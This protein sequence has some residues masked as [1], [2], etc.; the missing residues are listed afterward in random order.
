MTR[1]HLNNTKVAV[2]AGTFDPVTNGHVDIITRAACLYEKV[3]VAVSDHGRK[4]TIFDLNQRLEAMRLAT[5]HLSNVEVVG[6]SNLLYQL[7]EEVGAGVVIRGLRMTSDFD[8]EFQMAEMNQNLSASF[9]TVVLMA[10]S[11]HSTISS[12]TVKEVAALGGDISRF[13]PPH[14]L[15][16]LEKIYDHKNG[17]HATRFAA[18]E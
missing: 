5:A 2:Y 7:V 12:T 8:Y 14:V 6:F 1:Q 11:E 15:E 18:T 13:V 10:R 3:H 17:A 4:N 9:E 16:M